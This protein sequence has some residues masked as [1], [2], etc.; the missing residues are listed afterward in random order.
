VVGNIRDHRFHWEG[1]SYRSGS[2]SAWCPSRRKCK[3][4]PIAHPADVACTSPRKWAV[5]ACISTNRKNTETA[6]RHGEI[7]GAAG[8]RD[9]LGKGSVSAA[10]Q[11][12]VP[13]SAPDGRPFAT[14]SCS[15]SCIRAARTKPANWSCPR[16][17]FSCRRTLWPHGRHRP[18]GDS[19]GLPRVCPRY[20]PNGAK[21]AINLSGNSLSDE[22]CS[23]SSRPTSVEQAFPPERVCFEITENRRHPESARALE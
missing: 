11:P 22:P 18:L 20:R 1:R 7:L 12:I 19:D 15:R 2:V 6:Q 9:A 14:R 5:T 3:H 8:L 23:P 4:H 10:Y 16:P 17:S 21:I 13:L